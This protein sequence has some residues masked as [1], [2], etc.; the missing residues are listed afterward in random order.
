MN[1]GFERKLLRSPA[2]I[3]AIVQSHEPARAQPIWPYTNGIDWP[4]YKW[5]GRVF[6]V[7]NH[8]NPQSG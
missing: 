7:V 1:L 8:I 2:D 6:G 5:D 4:I 3:R